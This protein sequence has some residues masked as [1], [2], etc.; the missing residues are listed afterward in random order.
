MTIFSYTLAFL[1]LASMLM[2]M[3]NG[4]DD[5]IYKK[6]LPN[7]FD[8]VEFRQ[9]NFKQENDTIYDPQFVFKAFGYK[10]YGYNFNVSL[11][12]Q[13]E[14]DTRFIDVDIKKVEQY[15]KPIVI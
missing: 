10:Y 5:N 14:R 3:Y 9:Y 12:E 7:S 13:V 15:L 4:K 8:S 1:Y 2:T 6:D 11:G